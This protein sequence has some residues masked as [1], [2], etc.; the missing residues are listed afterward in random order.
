MA[1]RWRKNNGSSYGPNGSHLVLDGTYNLAS[2]AQFASDTICATRGQWY[3]ACGTNVQFGIE[4]VNTSREPVDTEAEAKA[5]ARKWIAT[6]VKKSRHKDSVHKCA[7]NGCFSLPNGRGGI[8]GAVRCGPDSL[9]GSK[10][11][12]GNKVLVIHQEKV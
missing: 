7:V 12:C 3:W 6:A 2:I 10:D 11:D 1:L 5:A 4:H 8:C 9:C